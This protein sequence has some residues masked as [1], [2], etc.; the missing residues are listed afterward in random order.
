MKKYLAFAGA[1][2]A[3][4]PVALLHTASAFQQP[5]NTTKAKKPV[6]FTAKLN[7]TTDALGKTGVSPKIQ[8]AAIAKDGTITVR[9]TIVDSNNL[10][11]DRLGVVTPARSP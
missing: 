3:L 2:L 6:D 9:V 11:L 4:A 10:A 1:V 5:V 8:S 7:G